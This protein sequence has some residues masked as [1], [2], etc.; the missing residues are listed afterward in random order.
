MMRLHAIVYRTAFPAPWVAWNRYDCDPRP[1]GIALRVGRRRL[2]SIVWRRPK[3][4]LGIEVSGR[5]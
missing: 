3:L 1:I 2:L 5:G 4:S